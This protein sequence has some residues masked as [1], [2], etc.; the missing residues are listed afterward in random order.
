[1]RFAGRCSFI[2]SAKS[3]TDLSKISATGLNLAVAAIVLRNTVYLAREV[4]KL[5]S[6]GEIIGDDTLRSNLSARFPAQ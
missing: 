2:A 4:D 5:R 1:M 3:V 6:Q